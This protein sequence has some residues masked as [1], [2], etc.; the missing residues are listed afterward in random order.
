MYIALLYYSQVLSD[1]TSSSAEFCVVKSMFLLFI[2]IFSERLNW[3]AEPKVDTN[4]RTSFGQQEQ[5][6]NRTA[7]VS[8]YTSLKHPFAL[9]TKTEETECKK[10]AT[11]VSQFAFINLRYNKV[12]WNIL[13]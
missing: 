13:P 12:L 7:S 4:L 8:R 1:A 6:I 5:F 3:K 10:F 2:Q 9:D 11:N